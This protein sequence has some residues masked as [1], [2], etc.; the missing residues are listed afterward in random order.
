[1]EPISAFA[2]RKKYLDQH[3]E[4]YVAFTRLLLS[5]ATGSFSLLAAFSGNLLSSAQYVALAKTSFPLLL[6]SMLCGLFVQY[7]LVT[8]PLRDL[9]EVDRLLEHAERTGSQEPIIHRRVPSR[10]ERLFF[11]CQ[12]LSFLSAFILLV[13]Y[14]VSWQA[15]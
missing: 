3:F 2:V 8:R 1:L 7:R 5:L 10:L 9:A 13:A 6:V 14:A 11:Q 15:T 4:Q 12:A